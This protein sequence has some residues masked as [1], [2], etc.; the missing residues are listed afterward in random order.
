MASGNPLPRERR[1]PRSPPRSRRRRNGHGASRPNAGGLIAPRMRGAMRQ[2]HLSD[3]GERRDDRADCVE[4]WAASAAYATTR[5]RVSR[6][7]FRC[8]VHR[9]VTNLW[10]SGESGAKSLMSL[11][12]SAK[13]IRRSRASSCTISSVPPACWPARS[14]IDPSAEEK[15]LVLNLIRR[16]SV[17]RVSRDVAWKKAAYT[18]RTCLQ[19]TLRCRL[20]AIALGRLRPR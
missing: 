5:R 11:L 1:A 3:R 12:A 18:I 4:L 7:T 19:F 13:E 14:A 2:S 6:R 20:R 8:A 9:A 17:R 16:S 10:A 15:V